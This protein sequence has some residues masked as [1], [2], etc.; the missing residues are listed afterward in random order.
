MTEHTA[1]LDLAPY[2]FADGSIR[3][4]TDLGGYPVF[5]LTEDSGVLCAACVQTERPDVADADQASD[6]KVVAADVNW[7]DPDLYCDHCSDRI[8]SAYAEDSK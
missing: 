7:E 2:R 1:H 5:Y 6:W 3:K 4:Y 8:E